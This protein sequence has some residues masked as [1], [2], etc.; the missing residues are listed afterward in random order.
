MCA[1]ST[2]PPGP[3]DQALLFDTPIPPAP[4]SAAD[5]LDRGPIRSA[6]D[7]ARWQPLAQA[8]GPQVRLGTSS[9]S[10]PG[11][12][13]LVWDARQGATT[14]RLAREGL[15][16]YAAHP[17]LRTVSLDRTFYRPMTAPEY[18]ELAA[19]VPADFRFM[20]KAP[21]RITDAAL[22]GEDGRVLRPNPE[23]LDPVGAVDLALAPALDGLG[24]KLGVL[25]F[26]ISPLPG[27]LRRDMPALID[28]LDRMLAA[29]RAE[30]DRRGATALIG[31]EVRDP[32]WL[33]PALRDVLR[34]RQA[35]YVLGVH[36][37]MPPVDAQL[38]LLRAMWPGAFVCRWSLNPRHGAHG[39]EA[40]RA[41]YD[42]FDRLVDPDPATRDRL[43]RIA[44]GTALAGHPVYVAINNK[45]EGSA[46]CS[47]IELAGAIAAAPDTPRPA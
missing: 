36:P 8:L 46:P 29:C 7:L 21:S 35:R 16:A 26:E 37:R 20:V 41:G 12:R 30:A 45:A 15:P 31:V 39:Y 14:A 27:A 24:A 17:L 44:R 3:P 4:A 18:A 32:D 11:W 2:N 9:W 22:R 19:Q 10:F 34:G 5:D 40:A 33:G 38:P 43:A 47:V 1:A 23:F 28:R 13:G 25:V 6:A 42:P